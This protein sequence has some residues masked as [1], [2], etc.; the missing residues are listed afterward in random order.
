MEPGSFE[1]QYWPFWK[2]QRHQ[3]GVGGHW[4]LKGSP[5]EDMAWEFLKF[6]TNVD[7]MMMLP[8][9]AGAKTTPVRRSMHTAE[10]WGPTGLE[11]WHVFYDALDKRPDTAPI[12]APPFSIEMTNIY[13]RYTSLAT[14]GDL[15]PQEALDQ[16]QGELED[17][18]ARQ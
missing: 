15:S 8:W 5:G 12:P 2:S 3:Y 6:G 7:V 14:N 9:M 16:M 17:L 11:N 4:M 18:Y 10:Y 1:V 13:V